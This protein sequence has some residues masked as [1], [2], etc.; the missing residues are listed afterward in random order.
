LLEKILKLR[1]SLKLRPLIISHTAIYRAILR[2][3][4]DKFGLPKDIDE[5]IDHSL[6]GATGVMRRL[7]AFIWLDEHFECQVKTR[8]DDLTA[9]S[10]FAESGQGLAFLPDDQCRPELLRVFGLQDG[11]PSNLW[12]LTHPDLRNVERIKLVMQ[13]LTLAFSQE[14][15]HEGRRTL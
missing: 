6:I 5:L 2:T 14:V 15:G 4:K 10:Y 11:I 12:L 7:P 13:H 3:Y 1:A 8:C 9:M